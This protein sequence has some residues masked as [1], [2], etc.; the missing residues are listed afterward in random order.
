MKNLLKL[1]VACLLVLS[2][3]LAMIPVVS[4]CT[5]A[6]N[7]VVYKHVVVVGVDGMG[8]FH[9][10]TDTPNMDKI[11][12]NNPDAAWTDYCLASDPNISAECWTSMLTGVNPGLHGNTNAKV[13][14]TSFKYNNADWPTLFKLIRQS[15]PDATIGC[16]SSWIGP[17][18]GM[19]E[20]GLNVDTYCTN[21]NDK[22]LAQDASMYIAMEKPEFFFCVFN[23][24]DAAGHSYEWGSD[25]FNETLTE[26]DG[27]VGQIYDAVEKAGMLE[28]TLFIIT[29]DHGGWTNGHG[30]RNDDT[31]YCYFGAVGKSINGNKDLNV[32]GRDLAAIVAYAMNVQG[33]P[34]WDS[35]IPQGMFKDNMTPLP[36]PDGNMTKNH[37]TE[38]TPAVGTAKGL[39]K[40]IDMDDLKMALFFDGNAQDITENQSPEEKG[41]VAYRDGFYGKAAY[42]NDGY[43]S[44]PDLE[45]GTESFAVGFWMK[46]T[47][48]TERNP[49]DP[50]VFG[51][52]DWNAGVNEGFVL[53]EWTSSAR[54]NVADGSA[55][56]DIDAPFLEGVGENWFHVIVSV[57]R[58]AATCRIYYN[59][60]LVNEG[61]L[62]NALKMASFDTDLPFNIGQDG[63]GS[64]MHKTDS[65]FDDML[66]FNGK[67]S[68]E[69][70]SALYNYYFNN[71]AEEPKP[72]VTTIP[73][74]V[75]TKPTSKPV[76]TTTTQ[77]TTAPTTEPTTVPTEPTTEPTT[78]PTTVPTDPTTLPVVTDPTPVPTTQPTATP[79]KSDPDK[80]QTDDGTPWA[81]IIAIAA[82]VVAIA[83]VAIFLLKKKK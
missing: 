1:T 17:A 5:E 81:L 33:N 58:P 28:D 43:V 6:A 26:V 64:Y 61:K 23:D 73:T 4:V 34:K 68:S 8:N 31:K 9:H 10:D 49:W 39:D 71:K 66:V 75:T 83:A 36:A 32:R 11:L 21:Y 30:V 44:V 2:V 53:S 24:V 37:K 27:Y 72:P 60:T 82:A 52:K 18:N 22:K 12:K 80:A 55:R 13:E 45:F 63:T 78:V 77:P 62:D 56:S 65:L 54:F 19:V 69:Q 42:L 74:T 51:N 57:D 40:F 79:D 76:D 3:V 7:R 67:I 47:N 35:Y 41:T 46:K 15:R 50:I 25:K 59:F 14:D 29:T 48:L 70:V 38:T 16:Y 20:A